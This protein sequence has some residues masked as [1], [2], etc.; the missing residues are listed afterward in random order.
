MPH[1]STVDHDVTDMSEQDDLSYVNSIRRRRPIGEET[2]LNGETNGAVG[3]AD[4]GAEYVVAHRRPVTPLSVTHHHDEDDSDD[5]TSPPP[6]VS[7]A[8]SAKNDS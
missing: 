8:R 5:E 6:E 4:G 1:E 2:A 3:S 7:E